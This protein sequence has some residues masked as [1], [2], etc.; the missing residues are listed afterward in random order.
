MFCF[1]SLHLHGTGTDGVMQ[2][3]NILLATYCL[4]INTYEL[5]RSHQE[6]EIHNEH[7]GL[8]LC[9]PKSTGACAKSLEKDC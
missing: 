7:S 3:Q 6:Y 9:E 8:Y 4:Y 1:A 5:I 2:K